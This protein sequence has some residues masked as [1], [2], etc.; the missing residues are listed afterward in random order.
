M[1]EFAGVRQYYKSYKQGID[2]AVG[3]VLES[4]IYIGGE[5]VREL[6]ERLGEYVG[7][8]A[9]TCANGTDALELALRA[10][11]IGEG[12]GVLLP[13]FNF[14]AAAETVVA[15]GAVPVFVEVD[16]NYCIDV[17]SVQRTLEYLLC[18]KKLRPKAVIAVDL[19][20]FA[21]NYPDLERL[22]EHYGLYLIE[23]A[24]QGFG[25]EFYGKKL[26]SF[27]TIATT[28]FFPTKPLG[29]FGDG[30]AVFTM[31]PYL[32]AKVRSIANHGIIERRYN[33]QNVGRN[34]RLDAVQAAIL[35]ERLKY[36]E[37]N[38]IDRRQVAQTY[39]ALLGDNVKVPD[40]DQLHHSAVGV[41]TI[42]LPDGEERD[43]LREYLTTK[44]IPT[45][46]YYPAPIHSF[47]PYQE[48][49]CDY[50][51]LWHTQQL[52]E[53]VLSL[54]LHPFLSGGDLQYICKWVN[55][56]QRRERV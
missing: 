25:G 36:L 49:P 37:Q 41:Y 24:A 38:I 14:V 21:P 12:D 1:L 51:G 32:A 35:L 42:L 6:E 4:G 52:C 34:S 39:N 45:M 13:S 10:L 9:I 54:P 43:S 20:G 56:H 44:N 15:V 29:C 23:D 48:Y 30:G 53:R 8:E 27:G 26:G 40:P 16:Q 5:V 47:A 7:A 19:F 28:S 33:H 17:V 31:N 50:K 2:A 46:I 3:R 11:G 22:C 55:A 18:Q